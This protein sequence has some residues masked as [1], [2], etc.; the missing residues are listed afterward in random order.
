[1]PGHPDAQVIAAGFALLES[2]K[3]APSTPACIARRTRANEGP[4]GDAPERSKVQERSHD[5]LKIKG[6]S[7]ITKPRRV[8][9]SRSGKSALA[10]KFLRPASRGRDTRLKAVKNVG[11]KGQKCRNEATI[12]LKIK[13][14]S[15]ITK[16]RRGR[17]GPP[18]SSRKSPWRGAGHPARYPC[19]SVGPVAMIYWRSHAASSASRDEVQPR[20]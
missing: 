1:M 14:G 18:V 19:S 12:L 4:E 13:G 16:P 10:L 7:R 3:G 15:R 9:A 17:I 2:S 8:P 20:G 5:L 6:G 11:P